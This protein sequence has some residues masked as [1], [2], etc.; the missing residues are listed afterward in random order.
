MTAIA[1]SVVSR[2]STRVFGSRQV[3]RSMSG[4]I[5]A[6]PLNRSTS[7]LCTL[8]ASSWARTSLYCPSVQACTG[9]AKP[10]AVI[11]H[12]GGGGRK[13]RTGPQQRRHI[14]MKEQQQER[15]AVDAVGIGIKGQ[16]DPLVATPVQH[17]FVAQACTERISDCH[18]RS[19]GLDPTL[20]RG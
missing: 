4:G 19:A 20:R 18:K 6:T 11:C 3:A 13:H 15:S 2:A 8:L 9:P 5:E 14:S 1:C 16:H 10:F 7:R 17:E 12:N